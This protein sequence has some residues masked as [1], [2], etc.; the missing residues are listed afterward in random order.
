MKKHIGNLIIEKGD[1][2][3]FSKLKEVTGYLSIN[4]NATLS[5]FTTVGGYLYIY[6]NAKFYHKVTKN[7]KWKS[8]DNKLFIIE[9]EKTTKG[10]KIYAGYNV[11]GIEKSKAKKENCFVAEKNNFFAHG[12][13]FKKA[14][15]DLQFKIISEKL[16]HEPIKKD[17][18]FTVKYYRILTGSCDL[19]CRSWMI[20]NNIPFDIIGEDTV[21]KKPIK[22]VDLLPMLEKSNA[23]GI[24]KLKELITF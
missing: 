23:Y 20:S 1:T 10:I 15:T 13:N 12:V 4:S 17:T 8:V 7:K 24:E 22:A 18:E 9:S 11:I 2:R 5:A 19:G 3:D 16:K 14:I 21:E 6:S